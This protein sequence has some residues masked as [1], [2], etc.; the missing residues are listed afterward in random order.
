MGAHEWGPMPRGERLR[1]CQ[2]H[3]PLLMRSLP[4]ALL[5]MQDLAATTGL[6]R[7]MHSMHPLFSTLTSQYPH[8]ARLYHD[9][10]QRTHYAQY[11]SS[12]IQQYSGAAAAG[13][14]QGLNGG[15]GVGRAGGLGAGGAGFGGRGT[16][17]AFGRIEEQHGGDVL[18]A[19]EVSSTSSFAPAAMPN[20]R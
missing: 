14:R 3:A 11:S 1:S 12:A 15:R 13:H 20:P 18:F 9:P 6:A 10:S 5:A 4:L 8:L 16:A 2:A 17:V 7:S 19:G